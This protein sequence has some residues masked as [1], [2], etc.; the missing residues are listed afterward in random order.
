MT[1]RATRET[2]S[3]ET[4]QRYEYVPASTL[5]TPTPDPT[6]AFRWVATHVMGTL[7]PMNASKRFRDGWEPVQAQAH[8]ELQLPANKDGHVELGGLMLCSMPI[9]RARARERYYAKQTADQ[10]ASVDSAY[11]G[12]NNPRMPLFSERDSEV[13]RDGEF[14]TGNSR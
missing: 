5:P 10:M 11:M 6:K 12:Q 3:R 13:R 8:P 4:E 7:D 1:A 14:G 2:V 9:E